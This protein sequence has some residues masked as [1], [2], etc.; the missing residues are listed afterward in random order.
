M[1]AGDLYLTPFLDQACIAEISDSGPDT[2]L[3]EFPLRAGRGYTA[4][5]R[6]EVGVAFAS[7]CGVGMEVE[8]AKLEM[9][10]LP[11]SQAGGVSG[12]CGRCQEKRAIDAVQ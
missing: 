1:T 10:P 8:E 5:Q 6:R 4:A 2:A 7:S 9:H 3:P 11:P 12:C